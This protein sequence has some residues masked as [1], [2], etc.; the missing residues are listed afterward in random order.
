MP[1]TNTPI[2]QFN[3]RAIPGASDEEC[4]EWLGQYKPSGYAVFRPVPDGPKVYGYRWAYEHFVGPIP[5]GHQVEH[6]CHTHSGCDLKN[7]CPHRRCC[8]PRHLM[9]VTAEE[10]IR[11]SKGWRRDENGEWWCGHGHKWDGTR[12]SVRQQAVCG[13]CFNEK[14]RAWRG[15]DGNK[16]REHEGAHRVRRS[17]LLYEHPEL[18]PIVDLEP[19]ATHHARIRNGWRFVDGAWVDRAGVE[20]LRFDLPTGS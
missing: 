11:L 4:W 16:E 7:D 3:E 8:N 17:A 19:L 15:R 14:R 6:S 5:G 18:E 13:P 10:N 2:E 20:R 1:N 9:A 12:R